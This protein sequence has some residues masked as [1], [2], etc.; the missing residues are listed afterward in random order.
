MTTEQFDHL[1]LIKEQFL[2]QKTVTEELELPMEP[3]NEII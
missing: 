3:E 2:Q 1:E